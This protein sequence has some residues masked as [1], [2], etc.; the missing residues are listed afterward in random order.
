MDVW[1]VA[2]QKG[3]CGKTTTA[4]LRRGAVGGTPDAA[5][6]G[7]AIAHLADLLIADGPPASRPT[8]T[9]LTTLTTLLQP[10]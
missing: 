5:G 7:E 10:V 9:T 6:V 3:G 8:S 1:T 4:A 2:N